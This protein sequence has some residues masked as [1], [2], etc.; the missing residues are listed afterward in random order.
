MPLAEAEPKHAAEPVRMEI[1]EMLV[2][3]VISNGIYKL[4]IVKLAVSIS[5]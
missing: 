4:V 1:L 2:V 5:Y 3:Q